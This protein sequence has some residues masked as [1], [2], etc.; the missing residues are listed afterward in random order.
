[1]ATL[2]KRIQRERRN[3]KVQ[4]AVRNIKRIPTSDAI[5]RIRSELPRRG[6]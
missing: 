6:K 5:G 4:K 2:G 1:M 3:D